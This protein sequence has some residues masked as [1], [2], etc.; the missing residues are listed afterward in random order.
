MADH[1]NHVSQIRAHVKEF[2]KSYANEINLVLGPT[3]GPEKLCWECGGKGHTR[4]QHWRHSNRLRKEEKEKRQAVKNQIVNEQK[5]EVISVEKQACQSLDPSIQDGHAEYE[6]LTANITVQQ[7]GGDCPC[8]CG[9]FEC[10]RLQCMSNQ[11]QFDT[12]FL[13][14][15]GDTQDL[16][17]FNSSINLARETIAKQKTLVDSGAS[18]N[19]MSKELYD[20]IRATGTRGY[21]LVDGGWMQVTA[22]GWQSGRQR[23]RRITIRMEI[24]SSYVQELEF[25][26]FG[27]LKSAGYDL[28]LGKPWLRFHNRKHEIDHQTN[29]MWI[30]S[31]NGKR[32]HLVGLRPESEEKE[33]RAKLL[34]LSTITWKEAQNMRHREKGVMF[35]MARADRIAWQSRDEY[36]DGADI[37]NCYGK[38]DIASDSLCNCLRINALTMDKISQIPGLETEMRARFPSIFED[39]T[40]VPPKRPFDMRIELKPGSEPPHFNPYRVTPLE[41]EEMKRQLKLLQDDGWIQDSD[42]PFAAPILFVKKPGT[43]KLRLCVDYRA[44]NAITNKDRYPLPHMEDL[45][46]EVHGS[47]FFTKLDLKAGYH[48]MRLRPEDREKTAFVT[49]YGLYE[50]TVVPFGLANAPSAFMRTMAKL[51]QKHRRYCVVYLDDILIH[52]KGTAGQ[53]KEKVEEVLETLKRDNWRVAPQKCVWGARAVE[54]IGY[55]VDS[56]GIHVQPGK[57]Q[58]VK[59]WPTP[60]SVRN[61]R[62]FLGLTGFYRRFIDQYASIARPLHEATNKT[63]AGGTK[64]FEWTTE[65]DNSFKSLKQ[66]L[67]SAPILSTPEEGNGKFILHCDASKFAIGSVLSQKQGPDGNERVIAYHSRKLS[68]TEMKY[69]AYDRELLALKES[70]LAWRFYTQGYHVT[71]NTDHRALEQILK[72]KTL[73]SRQFGALLALSNFDYDIKYIRGAKNVV[74]D[75]LSR[76]ADYCHEDSL[77]SMRVIGGEGNG[78]L[79]EEAFL[80]VVEEAQERGTSSN[81]LERVK[82]GYAEDDWL[83]PVMDALKGTATKESRWSQQEMRKAEVRARR[84]KLVEGFM[85]TTEGERLAVPNVGTLRQELC[86]EHHDTPLGGHF[87]R[88]RTCMALRKRYYWPRMART[89]AS[90]VRG[91]DV[92]HRIKPSNEKPFGKLEQLEIPDERWS[93]IGIDFI[94]KLPKSKNG[95]DCIVS[96]VD[97]LTKRAHFLSTTESGLTSEAFAK[98]FCNFYIR[99]HGVP[100]VIVSDQDPRFVSDFW[101]ALMAILKVRLGIASAYHPQTDGQTEKVNHVIGT[102]LRAFSRQNPDEWDDLLPLGEFAYNSSVHISTGKSPFELDLGYIPRLPIDIT[103]RAALGRGT[104]RLERRALTFA[105]SMKNN[106]DLAREKLKDAQD[107]QKTAADESRQE[108]PFQLGQQ[109]YLSTKNLPLTY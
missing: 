63:E 40:G 103:I 13:M 87:G 73:S 47:S 77:L 28:V 39:P 50:W 108:S 44:L 33:A 34:G 49:K 79:R 94:T 107:S 60:K 32:H 18:T 71:V 78:K 89:V 70:M 7:G 54:F 37:C 6:N 106:L 53:H 8:P 10:N 59:D 69:P 105:E 65:L 97:H 109:V 96:I 21:K 86:A 62:E 31:D 64:K 14:K 66:A 83:G 81:W 72:Q 25:T 12:L 74:A 1:E 3:S 30:D 101:Q 58:A 19:F 99:L 22:S 38:T 42:S 46:N 5:K 43:D 35:F 29:E 95:H 67:V 23:R 2:L 24:G 85:V 75:R 91:C 41:D 98:T 84:F 56:E 57:V 26:V 82:S 48:Q 80:S 45:L 9:I 68:Q 90:Y 16:L 4:R 102:Y 92:C 88:E 20:R 36:H 52:T 17:R 61:V 100:D 51:L 55:V 27:G 15:N 11:G 93:R 76:R 104:S